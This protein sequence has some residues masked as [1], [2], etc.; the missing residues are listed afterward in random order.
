M[1]WENSKVIAFSIPAALAASSFISILSHLIGRKWI[2]M[3]RS[4]LSQLVQLVI[5]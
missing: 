5:P 1:K 4:K 3:S 2:G